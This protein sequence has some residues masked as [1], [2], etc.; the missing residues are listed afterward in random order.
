MNFDVSFSKALPVIISE[1]GLCV[2]RDLRRRNPEHQ[3]V[4]QVYVTPEIALAL[5]GWGI[6]ATAMDMGE[7]QSFKAHEMTQFTHKLTP[8][9]ML[10]FFGGNSLAMAAAFAEAL[11]APIGATRQPQAPMR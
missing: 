9:Q 2:A 6:Q 1:H 10:P 3:T 8:A 11:K 4:K 5:K 7:K